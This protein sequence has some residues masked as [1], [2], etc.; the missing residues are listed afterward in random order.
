MGGAAGSLQENGKFEHIQG[1]FQIHSVP[2]Q[3]TQATTIMNGTQT[4]VLSV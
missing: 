3:L 4:I 1:F 2:G